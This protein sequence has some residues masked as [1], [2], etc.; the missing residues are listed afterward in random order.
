MFNV[1]ERNNQSIFL[2]KLYWNR[3]FIL[4]QGRGAFGVVYKAIY[5]KNN[6][7]YAIKKIS[8]KKIKE[9]KMEQQV[10][11]EINIS[12]NLKHPHIVYVYDFVNE[13]DSVSLIMEL[14]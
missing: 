3:N 11:K 6:K 1:K 10:T 9:Q 8:K 14:A 12:R 2:L 13:A 5:D 4:T 7:P